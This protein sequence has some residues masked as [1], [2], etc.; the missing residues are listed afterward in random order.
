MHSCT[1]QMHLSYTLPLAKNSE[2]VERRREVM[3]AGSF[4]SAATIWEVSAVLLVGQRQTPPT[5]ELKKKPLTSTIRGS[6]SRPCKDVVHQ[7][8]NR[9]VLAL[10]GMSGVSHTTTSSEHGNTL[11]AEHVC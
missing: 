9:E 10:L 11:S 2:M 5:W 3:S 7:C 1:Q 4:M 8:E 6:A